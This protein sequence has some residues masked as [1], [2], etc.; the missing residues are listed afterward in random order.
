MRPGIG[1][2]VT[3]TVARDRERRQVRIQLVQVD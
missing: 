2:T 1:A 3:L